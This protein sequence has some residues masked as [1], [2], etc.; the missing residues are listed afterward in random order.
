MKTIIIQVIMQK[1]VLF[2]S[3]AIL[4][5]GMLISVSAVAQDD[6]NDLR[7]RLADIEAEQAKSKKIIETLRSE[8]NA[9]HKKNNNNRLAGQPAEENRK[10]LSNVPAKDNRL[11]GQ[12]DEG[13]RKVSTQVPA[14]SKNQPILTST[15]GQKRAIFPVLS[16]ERK[17]VLETEDKAFSFEID[18][19][20]AGRHEYNYRKDDGTGFSDGDQGFELVAAR[21][22]FQGKVFKD[23]GYWT[24]I[25]ADEF[26]AN[27]V[28]DAIVGYWKP[29]ENLT[30]VAGQFPSLLTRE[31]SIPL[32]KLQSNEATPTNFTLA[33][34]GYKGVMVG[35]HTPGMIFRGIINDGYRSLNNIAFDEA[36]A[37]WA[38][39]GQVETML[40]GDEKD[41][42]RF[43]NFTS[44]PG[45][46]FA[47]K[48]NT[49]FHVQGGKS[50]TL[51]KRGSDN[52]YLGIV[53]SSMEGDGW[54]FYSSGYY[55]HTDMR[56]TGMSVADLGFVLQGA[57][58]VPKSLAGELIAK[59]FE[60]SSR[61]DM[62]IPDKDRPTQGKVFKTFTTGINFYPIPRTD[63]IR[64]STDFVYM[65]DAEARSIVMPN[66]FD[67]V[68]ASPAGDQFVIRSQAHLRW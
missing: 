33:P 10:V 23:F 67:S 29:T 7:R 40:V 38:F 27:P 6:L 28:F 50:P 25:S 39:A 4:F 48:L 49:A 61:F 22:N 18:G 16:H 31:N 65:F 19:M 17:F 47:W 8:I 9:L 59:H 21:I 24:R 35:Y 34:L 12:P 32:D 41:W 57:A 36:S 20:V 54:N 62:T 46:D 26:G 11:A 63:N 3:L 43:N 15:P 52:L 51:V 13:T 14:D 60:V 37:D 58:W 66:T 64:L 30:I 53:E 56:D 45:S 1:G 2:R 55:R 5:F 44:R 68:Q 42:A